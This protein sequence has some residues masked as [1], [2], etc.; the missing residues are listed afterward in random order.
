MAKTPTLRSEIEMEH[1]PKSQCDSGDGSAV[2]ASVLALASAA[3]GAPHRSSL[4]K[5]ATISTHSHRR[6]QT[7]VVAGELERDHIQ[8]SKAVEELHTE[9]ESKC[10]AL[11]ESQEE[12]QL[13]ARI[14]QTL[15]Q[16]NQEMGAEIESKAIELQNRAEGAEQIVRV[17]EKKLSLA[18]AQIRSLDMARTRVTLEAEQ[19]TQ[20]LEDSR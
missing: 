10:K 4:K 8:K 7:I 18:V 2:P 3:S 5:T 11:E 17:L 1:A 19:L 9:L 6:S 12:A 20:E 15:L 14:G 13:A 16:R